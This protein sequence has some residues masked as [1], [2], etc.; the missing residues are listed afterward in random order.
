MEQ[1]KIERINHL[2]KKAK[3]EGLTLDETAERDMLRREYVASVRR[4]LTQQL[5][6]TYFVD[7]NGNKEKLKRK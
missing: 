4:N 3:A 5:E 2:A 1:W 6:N 7:E